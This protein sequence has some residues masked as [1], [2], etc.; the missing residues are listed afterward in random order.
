MA[1]QFLWPSFGC[2]LESAELSYGPGGES[3]AA[4]IVSGRMRRWLVVVAMLA[5]SPLVGGLIG[6]WFAGGP[7]ASRAVVMF[8][9]LALACGAWVARQGQETDV[10]D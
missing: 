7:G 5:V 9:C 8:G 6:H 10:T 3:E 4:M 2:I 1:M